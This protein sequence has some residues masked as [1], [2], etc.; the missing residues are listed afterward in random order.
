M[1]VTGVEALTKTKYKVYLEGQFAFVLYKGELSRFGIREGADITEET[2]EKIRVEV[3]LKRAKLRAM[4]LLEDMDR[5]EA[6]LR[7]KL[8]QGLYPQEAVDKA[9][10]YVKSFGYLNDAR[11]A[12]NFVRSRQGS[13]S[14]RE[15]WALLMQKGVA[16]ELAEAAFEECYSGK[17]DE[18]Q[19][20][21]RRILKKRKYDPEASDE[22]KMQ[23]IYGY[24]ARKGFRYDT[25]RQVIQNYNEDA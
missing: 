3:I 4:H 14:R 20:A 13:K 18:E 12:E 10:D 17:E 19:E 23:K 1:I 25:V 5:T 15:I 2:E 7:E 16:P 6:A 9:I 11:Y 21:I 22:A 24:L 8:T